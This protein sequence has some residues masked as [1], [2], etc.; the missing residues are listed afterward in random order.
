M[1]EISEV[2]HIVKDG[3]IEVTFEEAVSSKYYLRKGI[4]T[5]VLQKSYNRQQW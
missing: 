5:N 4:D 2:T 3:N 1:L